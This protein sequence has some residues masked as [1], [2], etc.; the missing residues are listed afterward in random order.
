[1]L[2]L[3]RDSGIESTHEYS[4]WSSSSAMSM[5]ATALMRE[6]EGEG[7]GGKRDPAD[8]QREGYNISRF[9]TKRSRLAWPA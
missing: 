7:G 9:E 1:M 2:R 4:P 5:A 8:T 3:G 6:T